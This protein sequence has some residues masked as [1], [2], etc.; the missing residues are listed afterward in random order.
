MQFSRVPQKIF[1]CLGLAACIPL[2]TLSGCG[3]PQVQVTKP[4]VYADQEQANDA[5]GRNEDPSVEI[6]PADLLTFPKRPA[7]VDEVSEL[8]KLRVAPPAVEAESLDRDA[9]VDE[10]EHPGPPLAT[11]VARWLVDPEFVGSREAY[12]A[13][14]KE[15]WVVFEDTLSALDFGEFAGQDWRECLDRIETVETAYAMLLDEGAGEDDNPWQVVVRDMDFMQGDCPK[16]FAGVV[17]LVAERF[18]E[19]EANALS[20][21]ENGVRFYNNAGNYPEAIS[22]VQAIG[23]LFPL[24][25]LGYETRY[26]FGRSLMRN[27]QLEEAAAVF[28]QILRVSGETQNSLSLRLQLADILL[29]VGDI[30]EAEKV[31][32]E[33]ADDLASLSFTSAWVAEQLRLLDEAGR[34]PEAALAFQEIMKISLTFDGKTIPPALEERQKDLARLYPGSVFVSQAK[35]LRDMAEAKLRNWIGDELVKV[36]RLIEEKQYG[37]ALRVMEQILLYPNPHSLEEAVQKTMD[38]VLLAKKEEQ[39]ERAR[40]VEQVLAGEWEKGLSYIE[41]KQFDRAMESLAIL[42]ETPYDEKARGKIVVVANLA[43]AE[44]RLQA[45]DL[46]V[47]ANRTGDSERKGGLLRQSWLLLQEIIHKYPETEILDKVNRNLAVLEAKMNEFDPRLLSD[48]GEGNDSGSGRQ[49]PAGE[50]PVL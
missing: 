22:Q 6:T 11:P 49:L 15:R 48:A 8:A 21:M 41:A 25:E 36:D 23:E 43:A 20:Q 44:L 18:G 17:D 33:L 37:E 2:L 9:A 24:K 50:V 46:F 42:L 39:M 14:V 32:Q 29:A 34:Y 12:Y 28:R 40:M 16:V 45:A 30:A 38:E 4:T 19:F 35:V 31:Y 10:Y 5:A 7:P 27:G 47:Q 3:K 13:G 26:L 1:V